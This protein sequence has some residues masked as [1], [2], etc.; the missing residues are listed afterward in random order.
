LFRGDTGR[1]QV[2]VVQ[3]GYRTPRRIFGHKREEAKEDIGNLSLGNC[4][5]DASR[6]ILLELSNQGRLDW[7]SM[8]HAQHRKKMG[9]KL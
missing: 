9:M 4:V 6:Q 3:G 5:I 8:W 2:E 7:Q 1:T